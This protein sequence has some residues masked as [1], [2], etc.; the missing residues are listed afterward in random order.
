MQRGAALHRFVE[1]SERFS[2][3]RVIAEVVDRLDRILYIKAKAIALRQ[4]RAN[5]EEGFIAA[6][7]G[8]GTAAVQ[9]VRE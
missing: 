1:V 4:M 7:N 6:E 5:A 8:D 2:P 3:L 9:A